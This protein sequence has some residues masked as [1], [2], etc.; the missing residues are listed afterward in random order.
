M[1]RVS[2]R[3]DNCLLEKPLPKPTYLT[4]ALV[5]KVDLSCDLLKEKTEMATKSGRKTYI[6]P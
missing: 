3:D 2:G 1:H 4:L 5:C 6:H